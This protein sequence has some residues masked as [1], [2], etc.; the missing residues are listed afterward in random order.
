MLNLIIINEDNTVSP[1]F[2][3]KGVDPYKEA[4]K[5]NGILW[6][7]ILPNSPCLLWDKE[8]ESVITDQERSKES[9]LNLK[10]LELA[11]ERDKRI[12]STVGT[13]DARKKNRL[14][15][16]QLKLL[17]KKI[18]NNKSPEEDVELDS[19]EIL[20][21][22]L[23]MIDNTHDE[24]QLYLESNKRT[25]EEITMYDVVNTPDWPQ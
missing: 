17:Y 2:I 6:E 15:A 13:G 5:V 18:K 4:K 24:T 12:D 19:M 21:D 11:S 16:R 8:T 9:S 25:L 20:S 23:D 14:M 7:G 10:L 3:C 22:L 1:V